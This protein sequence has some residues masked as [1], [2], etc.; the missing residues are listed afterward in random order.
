MVDELKL[1]KELSRR[2]IGVIETLRKLEAEGIVRCVE[3]RYDFKNTKI[4]TGLNGINRI[5]LPSSKIYPTLVASDTN[6]YVSTEEIHADTIEQWKAKFMEDIYKPQKYRKIT[7]SEACRI[8]GFPSSFVLPKS[9]SRWMHLIGNSVAVPVVTMLTKGI[10]STGV[11][12]ENDWGGEKITAE[13]KKTGILR[14]ERQPQ[15][16]TLFD[17]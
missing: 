2:K 17:L 5:F 13:E 8:Q 10:V 4:S 1:N 15:E 9:R 11:F 6:D 7:K 3:L 14:I 12:D 16:R